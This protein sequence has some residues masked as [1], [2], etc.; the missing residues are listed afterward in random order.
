MYK[1]NIT[2]IT[3]EGVDDVLVQGVSSDDPL[4]D[5]THV[6]LVQDGN[7]R[8][9]DVHHPDDGRKITNPWDRTLDSPGFQAGIVR[10][11]GVEIRT[12][13]YEVQT[14]TQELELK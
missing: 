13:P 10:V 9:L 12:N 3:F 2:S 8:S 7:P 6:F 5:L 11:I 14:W 1:P 4:P